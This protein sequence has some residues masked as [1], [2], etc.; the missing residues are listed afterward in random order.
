MHL[1]KTLASRGLLAWRVWLICP[2]MFMDTLRLGCWGRPDVEIHTKDKLSG[3]PSYELDLVLLRSS[4]W[5]RSVR[6]LILE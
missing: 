5:G 4:C 6:K 1:G 3:S 2:E